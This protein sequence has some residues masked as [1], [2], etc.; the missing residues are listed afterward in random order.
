MRANSTTCPGAQ[1]RRGTDSEP[2]VR[3][4]S[5]GVLLPL[6]HRAL[7]TRH[8]HEEVSPNPAASEASVRRFAELVATNGGGRVSQ[9]AD[10]PVAR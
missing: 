8:H 6:D 3:C 2:R 10:R 5:G 9:P 4:Q 7:R 1:A